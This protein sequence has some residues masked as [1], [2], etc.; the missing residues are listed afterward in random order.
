MSPSV[1]CEERAGRQPAGRLEA[2][3]RPDTKALR[4]LNPHNPNPDSLLNGTSVA[5]CPGLL[6]WRVARR[7]VAC[8][9]AH[10]AGATEAG[11]RG[12]KSS[13]TLNM[14]VGGDRPAGERAAVWLRELQNHTSGA[15]AHVDLIGLMPGINPRPTARRRF[16]AACEGPWGIDGLLTEVN[17]RPTAR[18]RFP[19]AGERPR[20]FD[21]PCTGDKSPA[22]RSNECFYCV[23]RTHRV[24]RRNFHADCRPPGP[25]SSRKAAD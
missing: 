5:V 19:A 13:K 22:Y 24:L 23:R 4:S 18:R 9:E 1:F 11:E 8:G 21:G 7:A 3:S 14:A 25:E 16:P 15:E 20:G 10:A 6:C 17:P 2:Q 12:Q